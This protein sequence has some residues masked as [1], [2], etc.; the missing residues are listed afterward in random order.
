[1]SVVKQR[2]LQSP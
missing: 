1:M 2:Y